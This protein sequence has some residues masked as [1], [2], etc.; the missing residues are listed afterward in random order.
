MHLGE[1]ASNFVDAG[2]GMQVRVLGPVEVIDG[3]GSNVALGGPAQVK[4]LSLL[5]ASAP[6]PIAVCDIVVEI[7]SGAHLP[8]DPVAAIRTYVARL[9]QAIG[10]ASIVTGAGSYSLGSIRT[11]ADRFEALMDRARAVGGSSSAARLWRAA[12]D[13]W[14]SSAYGEY[15]DNDLVRP[16]AQSLEELRAEATEAWIESRVAVGE[17]RELIADIGTAVEQHPLREALRVHQ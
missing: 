11:D 4:L 13:L 17:G 5:A 12:L 6:N 15:A 1:I 14:R 10:P 8:A 7:W 16:R 9:R 2:A 3:D